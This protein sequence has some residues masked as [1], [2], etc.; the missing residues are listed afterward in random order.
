MTI[1]SLTALL[2]FADLGIGNGVLTGVAG[3]FG[4]SDPRRVRAL[5]SSAMIMRTACTWAS[6]CASTATTRQRPPQ[7]NLSKATGRVS[8]PGR[9]W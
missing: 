9:W 6:G 7:W 5:V 3:A 2:G 8:S 1:S 4:N